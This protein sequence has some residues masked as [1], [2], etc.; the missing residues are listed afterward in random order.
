[1]VTLYRD[2]GWRIAVYGR[3]HGIPHFHIEGRGF[4]CSVSIATQEPIIGTAP[5]T[6]LQAACGWARVN[7]TVLE[8]TW[9]E[10]NG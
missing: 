9:R 6:V 4:R 1:M 2:A 10:L 8:R 3:E 5:P 7:R